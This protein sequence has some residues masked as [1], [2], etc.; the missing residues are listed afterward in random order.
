MSNRTS[1]A[2]YCANDG[3]DNEAQY[4]IS[5]TQVPLCGSC[6][7]AWDWGHEAQQT[8]GLEVLVS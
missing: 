3:C 2:V 1:A 5:D 6:A 7:T 4:R 8:V